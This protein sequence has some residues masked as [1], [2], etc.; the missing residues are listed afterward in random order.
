MGSIMKSFRGQLH[1]MSIQRKSNLVLAVS[2]GCCS[3]FVLFLF[4]TRS[5]LVSLFHEA[6]SVT[7]S[8]LDF[9]VSHNNTI[10]YRFRWYMSTSLVSTISFRCV[11]TLL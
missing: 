1:K 9:H 2:G 3:V 7:R 10:D 5:A 11:V 4:L 8:K 6:T